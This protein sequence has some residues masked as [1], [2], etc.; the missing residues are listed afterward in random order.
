MSRNDMI[1]VVIDKRYEK[2][3]CYV[4]FQVNADEMI[5]RYAKDAIKHKI[6]KR[7]QNRGVAL[8]LAHDAQHKYKTEYGV[9][10][11]VLRHNMK[12]AYASH[13]K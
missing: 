10:E 6:T 4:F 3:W 11:I 1:L 7:T 9:H 12:P 13:R 5:Y 2:E 8:M